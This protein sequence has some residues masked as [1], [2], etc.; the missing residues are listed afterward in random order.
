MGITGLLV[1]WGCTVE[2]AGV[3]AIVD[4][5]RSEHFF[6]VPFPSDDLWG[7]A[8]DLTGF[9]N[10]EEVPLATQLVDA[11]VWR[12]EE[13]A[14]GFGNNTPAYFRFEGALDLPTETAGEPTDPVLWIDVSDGTLH[15]LDLRFVA[16]PQGDP[17]YGDNTLAVV[18]QLGA[19]TRSGHTYAV[20]VTRDAG[21]EAAEG[22][23]APAEVDAAL[24]LAGVEA[25]VAVAT[26]FTVAD[27]TGE[28][29]QLA[30]DVDARMT[31]WEGVEFRRV[32]QLDYAQ[33]LTESGE[34]ATVSTVHYEDGTQ[35]QAFQAANEGAEDFTV[36]LG[37]DWPMVVYEALLPV[38]NYSGL[39]GQ[40]YMQPGLSHTLDMDEQSGWIA[41][42][43]GVLAQE[44]D[45]DHTRVV[46][47]LPKDGDGAPMEDVPVM[48]WDHGTSGHA[49]NSVN[50][51]L[52]DDYGIEFAERFA[53]A[54]LAVVGRDAP[55]YGTRFPLIDEGY[56][57]GSLG[58]YNIVNVTAFRD[59][60]R[61][62]AIEG[63]QVAR[64][65]EQQANDDLPAGSIDPTRIRR[66]GHSLGSVTANLSM[67]ADPSLYESVLISGTGGVFSLYFLETGLLETID[68]G[69]VQL[70][71][72]VVGADTPDEVTTEAV[73][74]AVLGLDEAAW[75]HIDRM[76]PV[77]MLFQWNMDPSDPMAVARDE[78][79][80]ISVWYETGDWQVPNDTTDG[81]IEALP[82]VED[83]LVCT[84]T[85]EGYDPHHCPWRET[86]GLEQLELWLDQ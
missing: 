42:A 49:Y 32:V 46:V 59:N 71:F 48:V 1:L 8:L 30:Q 36:D 62:T 83:V 24:A 53:A 5:S 19:N 72:D 13:N 12:L 39:E 64:W 10:T 23:E 6:D 86:E 55:L 14:Q 33:G 27:A 56:S 2:Q 11:W 16:D 20:V 85:V 21:A 35:S 26:V 60:Q 74:G 57:G 34:P 29:Q 78:A 75:D 77:M 43:D 47:S 76:H 84:P 63:H 80:P 54:G 15:A 65:L 68:E 50:R 45:L 4:D 61:Q 41:F 81:L 70:I 40:P 25:E 82:M 66:F 7:G 58:F 38:Y 73:L 22:W 69:T 51:R 79:A 37:D 52:A 9:P 28:L 17:F 3:P 44:P 67:A 31:A 18:P